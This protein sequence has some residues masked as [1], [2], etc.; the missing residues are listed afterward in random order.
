MKYQYLL[1]D[2]DGTLLGSRSHKLN[3][4]FIVQFVRSLRAQGFTLFKALQI[5]HFQKKK[6]LDLSHQ[7]NG[8]LNIRKSVQFFS[9]LSG[10]PESQAKQV[11]FATA[12]QCFQSARSAFYP[13]PEAL[14]FLEWASSRY[15]LILATN[16]MWPLDIVQYRLELAGIPAETFEFITHAENMSACKPHVQYYQE[17]LELRG[18][19]ASECIMIGN[20]EYKDGPAAA[21]GVEVFILKQHSDF[22]L[23]RQ[24]L[25]KSL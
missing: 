19:T 14:D 15:K 24:K 18:L 22:S 12:R 1:L 7:K 20:D 25:E 5:L 11:L 9:E 2:L 10:L 13:I 3:L 6:M 17:L 8:V 21:V 4:K 23:L 16:P